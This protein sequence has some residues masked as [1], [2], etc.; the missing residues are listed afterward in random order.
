M[1]FNA[2]SAR[3]KEPCFSLRKRS[4]AQSRQDIYCFHFVSRQQLI[5]YCV[6]LLLP[7]T[8]AN[9]FRLNSTVVSLMPFEKTGKK[10]HIVCGWLMNKILPRDSFMKQQ[11]PSITKLIPKLKKK[12][13]NKY[14]CEVFSRIIWRHQQAQFFIIT[15][16]HASLIILMVL[17]HS[18][19]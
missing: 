19:I 8:G 16:Q 12:V 18:P 9:L 3:H 13:C 15:K 1:R 4:G 11:K 17:I 5:A 2:F 6:P 7:P 14:I 10:Y